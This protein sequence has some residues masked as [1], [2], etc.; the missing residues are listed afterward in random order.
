MSTA[1]RKKKEISMSIDCE[2]IATID[3][4]AKALGLSRSAF[5]NMVLRQTLGLVP[6]AFM[7]DHTGAGL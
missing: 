1:T 4:Q 3:A 2:V 5:T 7:L 6:D